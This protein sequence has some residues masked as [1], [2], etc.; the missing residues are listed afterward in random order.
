MRLLREEVIDVKTRMQKESRDKKAP[1]TDRHLYAEIAE[2]LT[3]WLQ[4]PE[5]F[6]NWIKIR[7]ASA[8]FKNRFRDNRD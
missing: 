1:I 7:R 3:L 2:W 5:I 4:S 6:A 8:D